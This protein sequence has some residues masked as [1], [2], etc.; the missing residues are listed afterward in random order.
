MAGRRKSLSQ[1]TEQP[2]VLSPQM[3][4]RRHSSAGSASGSSATDADSDPVR[5]KTTDGFST[6]HDDSTIGNRVSMLGEGEVFGERALANQG[7]REASV[8]CLTPCEFVVVD[9]ASYQTVL[10]ERAARAQFFAQMVAGCDGNAC[11]YF[12]KDT[13]AKG[14][15]LLDEGITTEPRIFII[16]KGSVE[17]RRCEGES[18][19]QGGGTMDDPAKEYQKSTLCRSTSRSQTSRLALQ[20][21]SLTAGD[22][23]GSL[24]AVPVHKTY[25]PFSVV[26]TSE[27]CV[28]HYTTTTSIQLIPADMM[29]P[30]RDILINGLITRL[31]RLRERIPE[32]FVTP[33]PPPD[34][35]VSYDTECKQKAK[36]KKERDR[37]LA[38]ARAPRGLDTT[39]YPRARQH[40][41]AWLA[42][43]YNAE[44]LK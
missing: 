1:L 27:E 44:F 33:L 14:H 25:E 2:E 7:T 6:F 43:T 23:F 10:R 32:A 8:K 20:Y 21:D 41:N 11:F 13:F 17:F 15:V 38:A 22:M 12:E 39:W 30:M 18:P 36:V 31:C 3:G 34:S 29:K 24:G 37:L 26:V 35:Y 9:F 28:V 4:G 16:E 40:G 5:Y 42:G 19:F